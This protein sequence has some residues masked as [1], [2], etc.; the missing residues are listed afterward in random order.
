MCR[1][2]VLKF[3]LYY[4][5]IT[6]DKISIQ[7]LREE[8]KRVKGGI[9]NQNFIRYIARKDTLNQVLHVRIVERINIDQVS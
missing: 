8:E 7:K 1:Y 6:G 3:I 9:F 2:Y 5:Y 4:D